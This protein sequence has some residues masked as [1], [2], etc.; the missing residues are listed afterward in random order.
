MG[1]MTMDELRGWFA[2]RIPDDWFTGQLEVTA[3]REEVAR[4]TREYDLVAVPVVDDDGVIQGVVTVDDVI[5][6]LV[7][8]HTEDVQRFLCAV[9]RGIER[10]HP[11][12]GGRR[13]NADP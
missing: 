13:R 2:G 4:L 5:D 11:P 10:A 12:Q 6:A 1:E 9:K 7:E 8:E 3:D